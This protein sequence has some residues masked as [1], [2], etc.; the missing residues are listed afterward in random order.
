MPYAPFQDFAR[1]LRHHCRARGLTQAEVSRRYRHSGAIVNKYF[2]GEHRPSD[3][4]QRD[5]ARAIDAPVNTLRQW[6]GLEPLLGVGGDTGDGAVDDI[7]AILN[8]LNPA[9][10]RIMAEIVRN[11][12]ALVAA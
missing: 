7:Q 8:R 11:A 1:Q 5:F 6:L 3:A 4:N 9:Q 2:S 12:A 10:R